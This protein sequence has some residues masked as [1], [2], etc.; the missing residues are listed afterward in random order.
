ME[1]AGA[2]VGEAYDGRMTSWPPALA[3][4]C[5]MR[6]WSRH[7]AL[8]PCPVGRRRPLAGGTRH[9]GLL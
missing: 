7:A 4:A 2:T 1:K 5:A 9:G 3:L 8:R 6:V